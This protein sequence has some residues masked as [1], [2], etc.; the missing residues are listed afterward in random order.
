MLVSNVIQYLWE[1]C[2]KTEEHLW[3]HIPH[4]AT[5]RQIATVMET[6]TKNLSLHYINYRMCPHLFP[7]KTLPLLLF[8]LRLFHSPL[9][10]ITLQL[11]Y[12]Y[13]ENRIFHPPF[14]P[15]D[16]ESHLG[17]SYLRYATGQGFKFQ[18]NLGNM[19]IEKYRQMRHMA[20]IIVAV[21]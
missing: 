19:F 6:P 12:L 1:I 8:L 9:P 20:T 17:I 18:S 3:L 16:S 13:C 5:L 10:P 21:A 15:S 14:L 4:Q 2:Y 11:S 7:H